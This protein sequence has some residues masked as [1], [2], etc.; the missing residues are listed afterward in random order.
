MVSWVLLRLHACVSVGVS[1]VCAGLATLKVRSNTDRQE[2]SPVMSRSTARLPWTVAA[3]FAAAAAASAWGVDG[4][5]Q[6]FAWQQ[7]EIVR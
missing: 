2:A 7:V 6:P 3:A 1:A 4:M 5:L